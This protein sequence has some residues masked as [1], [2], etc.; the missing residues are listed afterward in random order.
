[1]CCSAR[2]SPRPSN[3]LVPLTVSVSASQ[4]PSNGE[5]EW[6][7]APA[8]LKRNRGRHG[9]GLAANVKRVEAAGLVRIRDGHAGARYLAA[10]A[11]APGDPLPEPIY[12]ALN[13][14]TATVARRVVGADAPSPG[15]H[16]GR[17]E[18]RQDRCGCP[19]PRPQIQ[20]GEQCI[21]AAQQQGQLLVAPD[22]RLSPA[23]WWAAKRLSVRLGRRTRHA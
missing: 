11:S 15:G 16:Q 10:D 5:S 7:V 20:R 19:A 14:N 22:E 13:D 21:P 12:A 8:G 23:A 1:M 3:R 9:P 4:D 2:A 17:Y 18:Y 6:Q